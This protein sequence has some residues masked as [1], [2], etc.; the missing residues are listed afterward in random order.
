MPVD[1][2]EDSI[3]LAL[4]VLEADGQGPSYPY[5]S[6]RPTGE[7][8][9]RRLPVIQLENP[10]LRVCVVPDLGG[11]IL[12]IFDKRVRSEVWTLPVPLVAEALGPRGC[13]VVAGL[14]FSLIGDYR[15]QSMA[16]T[17]CRIDEEGGAVLLGSATESGFG[18]HL[19]ISLHDQNALVS[20]DARVCNRTLSPLP[21]NGGLMLPPGIAIIPPP[22][23]AFGLGPDA[24][25]FDGI[26]S[27]GARQCDEW[28]ATVMPV[29][30]PGA[31]RSVGEGLSLTV[32][33][34]QL[35]IES[36]S[37]HKLLVLLGLGDGSTLEAP[38][39]VVP[40][41]VS[42]LSLGGVVPAA[43][44]ILEGEREVLRWPSARQGMRPPEAEDF[45][46]DE[47]DDVVRLGRRPI[48]FLSRAIR[49]FEER[50]WDRA[51]REF[52]R[53]IS[54]NAD[55]P[56]LW[57]G[58]AAGR[59]LAGGE[60][61]DE[62]A[63]A[64]YLAPLEPLLR[65]EALLSQPESSEPSQLLSAYEA[66]PENYVE[67]A[68]QLMEHGLYDQATRWIGEALRYRD[69][70]MLRYLLAF[71]LLHQTRMEAEAAVQVRAARDAE[72][73]PRPWRPVEQ[74]AL[75][76]LSARFDDPQLHEMRRGLMRGLTIA[77]N[78]Q[79]V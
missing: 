33:D 29:R 22:D 75:E 32:L 72:P 61:S 6:L 12:S 18:W 20:F 79:D 5:P 69:L 58:K 62:L 76:R 15:L 11:R 78:S 10:S 73:D 55:D 14:Q 66:L 65:A 2:S 51:D 45:K 9:T 63:N 16:R 17:E 56:L 52:E 25:R 40:E 53:A 48:A 19:R 21:Y 37:A 7:I 39:S 27:L 24:L 28:S 46:V 1:V 67:V 47:T 3:E 68:C 31:S 74:V 57:W 36:V 26:G 13:E 60:G 34:D 44:A 54:Y 41:I 43:I 4:P 49:A 30:A 59:R 77:D 8:V 42:E 23:R 70:A 35:K 50:D 71:A 38:I 64:H